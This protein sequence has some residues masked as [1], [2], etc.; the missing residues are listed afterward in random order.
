MKVWISWNRLEWGGLNAAALE[1]SNLE[2]NWFPR[3]LMHVSTSY[4]PGP[5][6]FGNNARTKRL[7]LGMN[8]LTAG[9]RTQGVLFGLFPRDVPNIVCSRTG[10]RYIQPH[11]RFYEHFGIGLSADPKTENLPLVVQA[12]IWGQRI[13]IRRWTRL[14]SCKVHS[15]AKAERSRAFKLRCGKI[16]V[17]VA[18][19]RISTGQ[20]N[21]CVF[22]GGWNRAPLEKEKSCFAVELFIGERATW[23]LVVTITDIVY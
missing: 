21:S 11:L 13:C 2:K 6:V 14:T 12:E 18:P 10:Y 3:G 23:S 9:A 5:G 16:I 4:V 22:L 8:T 17:L 1:L 20:S 19:K 15:G 7:E